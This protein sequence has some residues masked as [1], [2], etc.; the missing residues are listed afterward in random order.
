MTHTGV[1]WIDVSIQKHTDVLNI[2][3]YYVYSISMLS[4]G[5]CKPFALHNVQQ[6]IPTQIY[7]NTQMQYSNNLQY[8]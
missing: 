3:L 6:C 5:L 1:I 8:L 4:I 7:M 2:K